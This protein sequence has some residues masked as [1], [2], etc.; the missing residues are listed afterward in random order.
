MF[1]NVVQD[2]FD[3]TLCGGGLTWDPALSVYKNAITNELFVTSSIAMYFWFPGDANS[4][5]Y[6]DPRYDLTNESLIL[7]PMGRLKAHDS[8]FLENAKK[9]W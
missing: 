9:G 6:P 2:K 1:Y 4:D 5:P 8:L 3:E 7:P